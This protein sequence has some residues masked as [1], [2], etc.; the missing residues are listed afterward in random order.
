MR[1]LML[2]WRMAVASGSRSWLRLALGALAGLVAALLLTS[3]LA[4]QSAITATE[5]REEARTPT[6]ALGGEATALLMS[7]RVSSYRGEEVVTVAVIAKEGAPVPPGVAAWP[8]AGAIVVSPAMAKALDDQALR[9]EYPQPIAAVIGQEG[10]TGPGE[11]FVYTVVEPFPGDEK[12]FAPVAGFGKLAS[13]G[14][15]IRLNVDKDWSDLLTPSRILTLLALLYVLL[16]LAV[17]IATATRLSA[18]TRDRKLASLRVIGFSVRRCQLINSVETVVAAGAGAL[19]GLVVFALVRGLRETW[20]IGPIGAYSGDLAIGVGLG[21]VIAVGVPLYA[22]LVSA[23]AIGPVVRDPFRP[24]RRSPRKPSA[25]RVVPLVLGVLAL[26]GAVVVGPV[27]PN[28]GENAAW[29]LLPA[30][31]GSVLTLV[32][33]L[34][35]FPLLVRWLG[36]LLARTR[37]FPLRLGGAALRFDPLSST[38][39]LA[40]VLAGLCA[41]GAGSVISTATAVDGGVPNSFV[42]KAVSIEIDHPLT[43]SVT[44]ELAAVDGVVGVARS[45]IVHDTTLVADCDSLRILYTGAE[46]CVDGRR[47]STTAGDS[48]HLALTP[49]SD[50]TTRTF[51]DVA[52]LTALAPGE[53]PPLVTTVLIDG[54]VP[55]AD[56]V[57]AVLGARVPAATA[58]APLIVREALDTAT[59]GPVTT[60]LAITTLSLGAIALAITTTDDLLRRRREQSRLRVVGLDSGTLR[61]TAL[62]RLWVPTATGG[63]LITVATLA[64]TVILLRALGKPLGIATTSV[65]PL[66]FA[67]MALC[68]LLAVPVV[69]A[70]VP[71]L[72]ARTL[73]RE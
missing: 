55:A 58:A 50:T 5:Q 47:Y 69:T 64:I 36:G 30:A 22:V 26:G 24:A 46:S 52:T 61:T 39:V 9:A 2:G 15:S 4:A 16:P 14:S 43:S 60:A 32:G 40:G 25:A 27:D 10:V 71:P 28:L 37:V 66:L 59:I 54:G 72:T 3:A 63:V 51:T 35:S 42:G 29:F 12:S 70:A 49:R 11:L 33:L 23:L 21:V 62:V 7:E 19:L 34:T 13:N 38:R 8:S 67:T 31:V 41:A 53:V 44:S 20:W 45:G 56:R 73:R 6:A 18:A 57:R 65:T 17:V 48:S 68:A 1:D